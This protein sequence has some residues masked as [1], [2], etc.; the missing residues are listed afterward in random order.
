MPK[1]KTSVTAAAA[2]T[3]VTGAA[4]AAIPWHWLPD[5]GLIP[6][7]S[8]WEGGMLGVLTG[9]GVGLV[10]RQ[11]DK[12]AEKAQS[13]PTYLLPPSQ[14]NPGVMDKIFQSAANRKYR[15]Q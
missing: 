10:M 7:P 6:D 15:R 4:L 2:G 13:Q 5:F 3:G 8:I 9:I 12:R 1:K 11:K 14:Q